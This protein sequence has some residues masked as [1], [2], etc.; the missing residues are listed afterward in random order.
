MALESLAID[1]GLSAKAYSFSAIPLSELIRRKGQA[2]RHV[3]RGPV[4]IDNFISDLAGACNG[5]IAIDPSKPMKEIMAELHALRP[6]K[7]AR[8]RGELAKYLKIWDLRQ[9][10]MPWRA[11]GEK[12]KARHMTQDSAERVAKKMV[13]KANRIIGNIEMGVWPGDYRAEKP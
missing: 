7:P 11:I 12:I 1:L 10:G 9:S 6:K 2:V 13:A 3:S 4:T 8:Q 5:L